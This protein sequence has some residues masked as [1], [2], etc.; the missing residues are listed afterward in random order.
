MIVLSA[1][2]QPFSMIVTWQALMRSTRG[3]SPWKVPRG[4]VMSRKY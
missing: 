4:G 2:V 3:A 1:V